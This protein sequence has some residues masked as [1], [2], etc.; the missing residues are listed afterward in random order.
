MSRRTAIVAATGVVGVGAVLFAALGLDSGGGAGAAPKAPALSTAP[1]T[2]TTLVDQVRLTGEIDYG[3]AQPFAGRLAGTITALPAPGTVLKAG[4][5]AYR[6]DD[7]PVVLLLGKL[8]AF[9]ALAEGVSG[10]D[11]KQFEENLKALGYRGFK[12]DTTYDKDTA[13]AVKK[14]QKAAGLPESGTVDLGRVAYTEAPVRVAEHKQHV[15]DTAAP[16]TP[17]LTTTGTTRS[18]TLTLDD[19]QAALA[20]P[21]TKVR[22][23]VPGGAAAEGTVT[24]A[25]PAPGGTGQQDSG[26]GGGGKTQATVVPADQAALS[27]ADGDRVEVTV[28]RGEKKDVLTVPIVALLAVSDGY[29]V[30]V[31]GPAGRRV[32]PVTV[33]M[34]AQGRVEVS[35]SGLVEGIQVGVAGQ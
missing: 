16:G 5:T 14:W 7:Q 22:L 30:E 34:F 10:P 20:K 9:R 3:L 35:G 29:G 8:P 33:G 11:V 32:V 28:V 21:G 23:Q 25:G 2:R 18:V 15:G 19:K 26:G 24:Q 13:A 1:V 4:D 12:V 31:S 17:V 27:G 6:V